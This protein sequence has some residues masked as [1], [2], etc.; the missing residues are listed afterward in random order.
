MLFG[1]VPISLTTSSGAASMNTPKYSMGY[2]RQ[3]IVSSATSTTTFDIQLIDPQGFDVFASNDINFV[4]ITGS[5]TMH[6]VDVPLV[7]I[8]TFKILN[9]SADEAIRGEMIVQEAY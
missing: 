3:V 2:V 7:G 6:K 9:A 4:G 5:V 1:R 8:Y